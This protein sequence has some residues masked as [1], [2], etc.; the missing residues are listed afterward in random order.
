ME[1]NEELVL[2]DN[3]EN[4]EEQTTEEI[5]DGNGDTSEEI[6][7]EEK[8]PIR[9]Y[10]DDEVNEIVKKKLYRKE[11]KI[12]EEYEKKYGKVEELLKAGLETDSFDDAVDSLQSFYEKKGIKVNTPKY[13]KREEELLA[14]AEA[15]DI[16]S[17]G[18]DE[19]SEETDRLAKLIENATATERDK[20]IFTKI[21]EERKR[22]IGIKEL[23]SIGV[24]AEALNDS[25]FIKFEKNLNPSMSIKD[26]YEMYLQFK[27]KPKVETIGSMKNESNY[28]EQVKEFY[29]FDEAS[30]FTKEDLDKNPELMKAI[31]RSMMKW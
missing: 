20:R 2:E 29:T 25:E 13:S 19:I 12:R 28:K 5:V 21:A 17:G 7:E 3:T 15:E 10:T 24:K 18:F 27:P 1:N 8:A 22:Q 16:I 9:T 6:V 26:K 11:T 30:K 23:A 4:V 14:N 31:E